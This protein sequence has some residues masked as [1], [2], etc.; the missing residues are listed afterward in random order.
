M[1]ALSVVVVDDE[2]AALELLL[3]Y[4]A[5]DPR[6]EV[7]G[8]AAD[9]A[10]AV[11]L[12]RRHRPGLLLLDVEMPGLD[13]FGVLA[14]LQRSVPAPL[15][16]VVFVTAFDRYAVR[17]FEVHAVDYL[18]KPVTQAR[19]REAIDHSLQRPRPVISGEE[20]AADALRAAPRRLLVRERERIVP[21][22]VPAVD[23]L[24]AEGDYVRIHVGAR[25][26]LVERTLAE[27][28][29][30]LAASGFLRIHRGAIVNLDRVAQLHPEGSGRYRLFLRDGTELIVSRS[31][32][33][34]F[35]E[36]ML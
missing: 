12:V 18:L 9:G 31:Y 22:P 8:Q 36:A 20:L 13:G 29:R 35:R 7:V 15:P 34:R 21:V 27:M 16:R 32:S 17:A 24:E 3:R 28:E 33:G 25:T 30:A 23:W 1:A 6:L 5:A 14:H 2:P 26:H 4:A 19:F 11:S 10:S